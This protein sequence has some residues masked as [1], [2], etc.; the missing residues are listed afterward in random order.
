MYCAKNIEIRVVLWLKM[1]ARQHV[2]RTGPT[3]YP[4]PSCERLSVDVMMKLPRFQNIVH[5]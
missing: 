1:L 2:V 5:K 4:M 3:T